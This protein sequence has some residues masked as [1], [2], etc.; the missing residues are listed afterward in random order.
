[1]LK[2]FG[3]FLLPWMV[4]FN[5]SHA[6][7]LPKGENLWKDSSAPESSYLIRVPPQVDLTSLHRHTVELRMSQRQNAEI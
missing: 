2:K 3:I 7:I 5:H 1:M 6:T 4:Y